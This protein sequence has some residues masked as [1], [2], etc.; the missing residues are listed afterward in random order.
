[1]AFHD[2]EEFSQ[3][4]SD[5]EDLDDD[6]EALRR[7]C[8]LT[9]SAAASATATAIE[10]PSN[11]GSSDN[12]DSDDEDDDVELVRSIQRRFLV[13]DEEPLSLNP[14]CSLPPVGDDYEDDFETLRAIQR[15]FSDYTDDSLRNGIEDPLQNCEQVG[16]TNIPWEKETSNNLFAG[17]TN[18]GEGFPDSVDASFTSTVTESSIDGLDGDRPHSGFFDL[19]VSGAGNVNALP[20]RDSGFP[21]SAQTFIDA[22]KKNRSCQKFLRSKL[23]QLEARIEENKKLRQHVKILK[24]FQVSCRK[25]TGRAL[26][27][28]KDARVQLISVPKLRANIKVNEKKV[29]AMYYGPPENSHVFTADGNFLTHALL[30]S[31]VEGYPVDSSDVDSIITS[32]RDHDITP[33][34]L[35]LFLPKVN[36]ENLVSM[37]VSGRSGAECEARW[38]T[39]FGRKF[40]KFLQDTCRSSFDGG[41]R[42]QWQ[43]KD[44]ASDTSMRPEVL[45]L[46]G[47]EEVCDD[48]W[49]VS[50]SLNPVLRGMFTLQ[51]YYDV[52]GDRL[53][54]TSALS[55]CGPDP[56]AFLEDGKCGLVN[57]CSHGDEERVDADSWLWRR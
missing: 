1:M 32:I 28:K 9:G 33:E 30:Y 10:P 22:I 51:M 37:Y 23:I 54:G 49:S 17:K 27:Q 34:K 46:G 41:T 45:C 52:E 44:K 39:V 36:W 56:V 4:D 38:G 25:R 48:V 13:A 16:A 14:L 43:V 19:H 5:D 21:K 26:S 11:D 2:D 3:T 24:D 57:E 18:I 12:D 42:K 6:M 35:R 53:S 7:A 29:P 20:A 8:I 47:K 50:C 15:R 55:Q 40:N 31:G